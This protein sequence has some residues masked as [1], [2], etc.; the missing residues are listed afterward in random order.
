MSE[1]MG[2]DNPAL[3]RYK[4]GSAGDEVWQPVALPDDILLMVS[5]SRLFSTPGSLF[6]LLCDSEENLLVY[7][8]LVRSRWLRITEPMS[9][10]FL[11]LESLSIAVFKST[12]FLACREAFEAFM[13]SPSMVYKIDLEA[14]TPQWAEFA[15]LPCDFFEPSMVV[16]GNYLHVL[17]PHPKGS[18]SAEVFS[19]RATAEDQERIWYFNKLP[20]V[21]AHF[22]FATVINDHLVVTCKRSATTVLVYMYI[23][24]CNMYL[25]LSEAPLPQNAAPFGSQN[26]LFMLEM[27]ASTGERFLRLHV[28]S[29]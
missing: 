4:V 16:Q 11:C 10:S 2:F 15:S 29:M 26:A 19:I 21:P 1:L 8:F 27:S 22:Q 24:E 3:F 7:R 25:L 20:P 28:L 5:N 23:P 17:R 9:G 6:A 13:D 18:T 12:L 14:S